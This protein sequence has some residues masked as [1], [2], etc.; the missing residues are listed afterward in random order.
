[1]LAGVNID[2]NPGTDT[3]NIFALGVL[4]VN[5]SPLPP[6]PL[7]QIAIVQGLLK[8]GSRSLLMSKHSVSSQDKQV[9][10]SE[11]AQ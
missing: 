4:R 2:K 3:E 8:C 9:R 5:V 10:Y 6:S 7:C 1:M 11:K